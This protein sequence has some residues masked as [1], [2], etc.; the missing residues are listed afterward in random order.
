ML[1]KLSDSEEN[2]SNHTPKV[3]DRFCDFIKGIHKAVIELPG[4]ILELL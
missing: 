2:Q 1:L 3:R 4:G